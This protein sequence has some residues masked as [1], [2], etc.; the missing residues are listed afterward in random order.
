MASN[1]TAPRYQVEANGLSLRFQRLYAVVDT[2]NLDA[3][4]RPVAAFQTDNSERAEDHC[5]Q[6]NRVYATRTKARA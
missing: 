5:H 4:G 6:A 2:H 1:Q 3:E